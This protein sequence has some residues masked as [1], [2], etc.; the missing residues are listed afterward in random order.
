M[1]TGSI[2]SVALHADILK[3]AVSLGNVLINFSW[4]LITC[5]YNLISQIKLHDNC[6]QHW[7]RQWV[8]HV[9]PLG[10]LGANELHIYIHI[11]P[12]Q[13]FRLSWEG[14]ASTG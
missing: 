1:P 4:H 6:M 13:P 3:L 9:D 12:T 7:P 11:K 2:N 5:T 14:L 8:C 10:E